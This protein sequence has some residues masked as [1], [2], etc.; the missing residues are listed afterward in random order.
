MCTEGYS[1][2]GQYS[3]TTAH[4]AVDLGK[5]QP[6]GKHTLTVQT[7]AQPHLRN[8]CDG[9]RSQVSSNRKSLLVLQNKPTVPQQKLVQYCIFT[10]TFKF[11]FIVGQIKSS[12]KKLKSPL[13]SE[14]CFF[15]CS[16]S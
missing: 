11:W 7:E 15:S 13:Q 16:S 8:C 1:V 14:M 2:I 12:G 5:V 9:N 3:L 10:L 4:T 6:S